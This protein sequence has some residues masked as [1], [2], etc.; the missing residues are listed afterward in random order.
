MPLHTW[1]PRI[2]L[3]TIVYR[4]A[5][6]KELEAKMATP[7]EDNEAGGGGAFDAL[8]ED[9]EFGGGGLMVS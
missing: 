1:I 9:D 8:D 4:A 5:K 3:L 2:T 7:D 6:E